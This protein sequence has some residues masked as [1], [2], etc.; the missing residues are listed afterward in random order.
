[1]VWAVF[2]SVFFTRL[3]RFLRV[4]ECELR[5]SRLNFWFELINDDSLPAFPQLSLAAARRCRIWLS[6]SAFPQLFVQKTSAEFLNDI[7]QY[8]NYNNLPAEAR[9]CIELHVRKMEAVHFV[10][11]SNKL[12]L[13]GTLDAAGTQEICE[14]FLSEK[15]F[16]PTDVKHC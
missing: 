1:V 5:G 4:A 14:S 3:L 15:S 11:M 12:E 6:L 13:V 2:V 10:V 8:Q 16:A 9:E 7:I